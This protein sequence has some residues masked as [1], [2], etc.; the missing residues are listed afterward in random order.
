MKIVNLTD[1]ARTEREVH[2]PKGGFVSF[3]FLL[4]RDGLGFSLHKTIIPRGEEQHWHYKHHLEACY[5]V[6]GGGWLTNLG[7]DERHWVGPD[8]V[9]ALDD[10]DEHTFQ[11]VEDTVLISVFNPPVTGAEVHGPDGSYAKTTE[12]KS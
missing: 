7:N 8:C 5:C 9:Y 12:D 10:H 4:A 1:I 2:C 11:A 6:S 3:R